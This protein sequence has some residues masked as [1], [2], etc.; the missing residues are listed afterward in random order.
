MQQYQVK[1]EISAYIKIIGE[2]VKEKKVSFTSE[3]DNRY[4]VKIF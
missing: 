2:K 3:F 1:Y 4:M